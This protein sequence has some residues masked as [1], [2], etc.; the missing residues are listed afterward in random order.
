M[1]CSGST[2]H[3]RFPASYHSRKCALL[4]SKLLGFHL[5]LNAS[6]SFL[7]RT[8]RPRNFT[9][10]FSSALWVRPLLL[11]SS[12]V[13]EVTVVAVSLSQGSM[14]GQLKSLLGG[15]S[16]NA[17]EPRS[18]EQTESDTSQNTHVS[19]NGDSGGQSSKQAAVG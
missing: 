17:Q 12:P 5:S 3:V 16:Q 9:I 6:F 19:Q 14:R 13:P 2:S 15:T 11:V 1:Y 10:V 18:A 4:D 7:Y 8:L